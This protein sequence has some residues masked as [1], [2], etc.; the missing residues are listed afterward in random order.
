MTG[1]EPATSCSQSRRSSQAELHPVVGVTGE[2]RF[3]GGRFAEFDFATCIAVEHVPAIVFDAPCTSSLPGRM[4]SNRLGIAEG[5]SGL[6]LP[7][8]LAEICR[9]DLNGS[10]LDAPTGERSSTEPLDLSEPRG[11]FA[12]VGGAY[13]DRDWWPTFADAARPGEQG[14]QRLGPVDGDR[15]GGVGRSDAYLSRICARRELLK[16]HKPPTR[17]AGP[18]QV[19]RPHSRSRSW[20]KCG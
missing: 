9:R 11:A 18:G 8:I 14:R 19:A 20:K 17:A 6:C 1:F 16:S 15:P 4:I 2:T 13:V 5:D 7:A 12:R 3:K 10:D